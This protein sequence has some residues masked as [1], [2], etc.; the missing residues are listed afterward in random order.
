MVLQAQLLGDAAG[1]TFGNT[2]IINGDNVGSNAGSILEK[3][4]PIG[5]LIWSDTNAM[6]GNKI[7][8][9]T[10]N[11][12]ILSGFPNAGIAGVAFMKYDSSGSVLWQNLNADGSEIL[13]LHGQ[14]RLDDS[15]NAY[16]S[17][18]NLFNMAVC[19]INSDGTYGW[20]GLVSG[21]NSA[22]SFVR[23]TDNSIYI[24]G[25]STAKLA[26]NPLNT[27]DEKNKFFS[28]YPNPVTNYITIS[29]AT[30]SDNKEILISSLDGKIVYRSTFEE[31][32]KTL[33]ISAIASGMY[34]VTILNKKS[35]VHQ[36]K[37]YKQ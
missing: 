32:T 34:I 3:Y 27:I 29:S 17:A 26:E 19:K 12:P 23:D 33:D 15:N 20:V 5:V 9:G 22:S 18:G 14:L 13:L 24:I 8:I 25:T 4:N 7:E 1:D 36:Q 30:N 37:I 28:I 11:N 31:N 35:F 6:S 10:D 21:S 2:Y 16:L